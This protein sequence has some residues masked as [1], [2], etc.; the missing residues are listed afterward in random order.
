MI[1]ESINKFAIE[2]ILED[3][4][5]K[6]DKEFFQL[7]N[8]KELLSVKDKFVALIEKLRKKQYEYTLNVIDKLPEFK[9]NKVEWDIIDRDQEISWF[10]NK[11]ISE[12]LKK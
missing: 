3:D 5:K 12:F 4:E 6:D 10:Y 11:D 8:E 7:R 9:I 2:K 1:I